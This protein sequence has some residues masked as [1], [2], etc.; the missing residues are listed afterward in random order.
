MPRFANRAAKAG[1]RGMSQTKNNYIIIMTRNKQLHYI[2]Y[3]N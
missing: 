1:G 2:E 3:A